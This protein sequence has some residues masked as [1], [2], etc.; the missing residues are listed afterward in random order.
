M[1]KS[2]PVVFG[3]A[4]LATLAGCADEERVTVREPRAQ[5]VVAQP[6]YQEVVIAQ[7]PAVRE[8][9][10]AQ[11]RIQQVVVAQP[12]VQEVIV[13]SPPVEHIRRAPVVMYGGQRVYWH[14][15]R[16]YYQNGGRWTYYANEP[17][18]LRSRRYVV[19]AW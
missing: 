10:V 19:T 18:E 2:L 17:V 15:N 13:E 3:L 7:Q 14:Q 11:P 12:A 9:V 1:H 5:V 8:V 16:W 6:R 4:A